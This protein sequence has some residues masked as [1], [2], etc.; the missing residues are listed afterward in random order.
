MN[1]RTRIATFIFTTREMLSWDLSRHDANVGVSKFLSEDQQDYYNLYRYLFEIRTLQP[2]GLYGLSQMWYL[3]PYSY[4]RDRRFITRAII[5]ADGKSDKKMELAS[6]LEEI[7]STCTYIIQ[8][9]YQM[10]ILRAHCLIG[11]RLLSCSVLNFI[12]KSAY[13]KATGRS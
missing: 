1:K 12:F 2:Q 13:L 11:G 8:N 7:L 6:W 3:S 4:S 10:K 9:R 5:S